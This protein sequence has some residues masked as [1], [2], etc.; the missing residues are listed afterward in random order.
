MEILCSLSD[1]PSSPQPK[2]QRDPTAIIDPPPQPQSHQ[3]Y[4]GALWE[5]PSFAGGPLQKQIAASKLELPLHMQMPEYGA[6]ASHWD[7]SSFAMPQMGS[8]E[9]SFSMAG[10]VDVTPQP[11]AGPFA[12]GVADHPP[13][14]GTLAD[15]LTP[16]LLDP[17]LQGYVPAEDPASSIGLDVPDDLFTMWENAPVGFRCVVLLTLISISKLTVVQLL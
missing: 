12:A 2:R 11:A 16:Y 10:P 8:H 3:D 4:R 14:F 17:H 13:L 5:Q 1:N 15:G 6:P 7:I 9:Q